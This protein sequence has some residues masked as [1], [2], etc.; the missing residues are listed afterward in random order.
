ML[1]LGFLNCVICRLYEWNFSGLMLVGA[2]AFSKTEFLSTPF[3]LIFLLIFRFFIHAISHMNNAAL[4]KS[5]SMSEAE[6][7]L[8]MKILMI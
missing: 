1:K 6:N 3:L 5:Q 4:Q 2:M 7:I 8:K